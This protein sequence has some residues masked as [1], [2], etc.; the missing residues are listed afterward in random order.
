[1]MKKTLFASTCAVALLSLGGIGGALA[2]DLPLKA[3][4]MAPIAVSNW[5][6]GYIGAHVGVAR[7]NTI[8]DPGYGGAYGYYSCGYGPQTLSGSDTN[9]LGGV[10]IGYD[11]QDR[12]F[13][14]GVVADWSWTGLKVKQQNSGNSFGFEAKIDWLASFRG[15]AGLAVENTLVYVTGGVALGGVKAQ[16]VGGPSCDCN[17][18]TY[19]TLDKTRVGWVAG[20]GFEHKLTSS[21]RWSVVGEVLYYD[22]GRESGGAGCSGCSSF[23]YNNEYHFEVVS[24]RVGVNYKF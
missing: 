4:P 6:G 21:P 11:W 18:Y 19:S 15:R 10:Q 22:L 17:G 2:A 12:T 3:A 13:V 9:V 1:M 5:Q 20:V 23:V 7:L 8:C 24:A 14:Y 16:G